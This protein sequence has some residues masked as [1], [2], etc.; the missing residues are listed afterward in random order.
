LVYADDVNIEGENLDTRTEN[1]EALL[2]LSRKVGV[3]MNPEKSEYTLNSC[4]QKAG[5]KHGIKR[6]NRSLED[7]A[8]IK[9]L[10]TTL[11]DENCMHEDTESR[12]N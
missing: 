5:C 12:L 10:R 1:K 7:V 3:E 8:K 6:L 9:Y 4:Y 2:D 11:T